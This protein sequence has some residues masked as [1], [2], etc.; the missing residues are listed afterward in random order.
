MESQRRVP[1]SNVAASCLPAP[2]Y[3][4]LKHVFTQGVRDCMLVGGTA[5]A[6]YYAAHRRSDDLDLFCADSEAQAAVVLAVNSLAEL[7]ATSHLHQDSRQFFSGV[8]QLDGHDFTVQVVTDAHL[9][10]LEAPIRA[11]D[12]VWVASLMG[13]LRCKAATLVSRCSEKDLFDLLWL[14]SEFSD[15]TLPEVVE[16]GSELDAGMDV[17]AAL[18]GV[19]GATLREDACDFSEAGAKAVFAEIQE[20]RQRLIASLHGLA[21]RA[22]IPP[23]GEL[24]RDLRH[25]RRRKRSR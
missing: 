3:R 22:P 11:D 4:A 19:V 5:L 25:K 13:L 6:G 12:G 14:F 17:E 1:D 7:G 21:E 24:V 20:F 23:V 16:L 10:E 8:F 9:F 18:M 15:L 2:L